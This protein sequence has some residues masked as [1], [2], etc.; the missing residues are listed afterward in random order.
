MALIK[1]TKYAGNRIYDRGQLGTIEE[2]KPRHYPGR[3][4]D[5][6]GK[7]QRYTQCARARTI[8]LRTD[9]ESSEGGRSRISNAKHANPF[10]R[11]WRAH[12]NACGNVMHLRTRTLGRAAVEPVVCTGYPPFLFSSD[13]S[14]IKGSIS[15]I[16]CKLE[17]PQKPYHMHNK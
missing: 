2:W 11:K 14:C 3:D 7:G 6:N 4:A 9:L 13:T 10:K 5:I 15:T 16:Q 8:C 17:M 1:M 12:R